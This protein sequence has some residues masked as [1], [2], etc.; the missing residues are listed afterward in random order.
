MFSNTGDNF[1]M[2]SL[3]L[4]LFIL[5]SVCIVCV[6]LCAVFCLIVVLFVCVP[7]CSTTATG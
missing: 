7:Y 4:S 1:L 2:K 6:D 3:I 5:C